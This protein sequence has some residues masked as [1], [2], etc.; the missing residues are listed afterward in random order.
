M[1][2][3]E[4][5]PKPAA[6][7]IARLAEMYSGACGFSHPDTTQMCKNAIELALEEWQAQSTAAISALPAAQVDG[8][9][10][11]DLDG[12]REREE[13]ELL[14]FKATPPASPAQPASSLINHAEPRVAD[15]MRKD[16]VAWDGMWMEF[17]NQ[18]CRELNAVRA[19]GA[20]PDVERGDGVAP[21]CTHL[22]YRLPGKAYPRTCPECGLGPCKRKAINSAAATNVEEASKPPAVGRGDAIELLGNIAYLWTLVGPDVRDKCGCDM[23]Q[24]IHDAG[25]LVEKFRVKPDAE[26]AEGGEAAS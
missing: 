3:P 9:R 1:T 7:A 12:W 26:R 14:A 13:R 4:S 8:V 24:L 5:S 20:Q 25:L 17:A 23:Y 21:L 2:T 6:A 16:H 22:D 11:T 18:L 19:A 15:F 10:E